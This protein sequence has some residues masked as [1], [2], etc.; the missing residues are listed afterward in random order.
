MR[1]PKFKYKF[2][3]AWVIILPLLMSTSCEFGDTNIDPVNPVPEEVP[4]NLI[5][6]S[7]EAQAA[8][9]IGALGGRMPGIVMQYYSGFDAQQVAYEN[10]NITEV[11]LNNLWNTGMY[12]GVMKDCTIMIE[13]AEAEGNP[14]YTGIAKILL[15]H[16]LGVTTSFFG[17]LPYSDAFQGIDN[18]LPIYDTQEQIYGTI[19]TLLDEAITALSEPSYALPVPP[20]NTDVVFRGDVSKWIAVARSLKARHYMHLT[21]KGTNNAQLALDQIQTGVIAEVANE[22]A[23]PFEAAQTGANPYF[24][25]GQQRPRTLIINQSFVDRLAANN[26]PRQPY[27]YNNPED[28]D[29]DPVFDFYQNDNDS[30]YWSQAT[31]PIPLISYAEVKLIE[32]EAIVRTG[33]SDA[34]AIAALQEAISTNM[35]KISGERIS[36]DQIEAYIASRG[37]FDGLTTMDEKI[38]RIIEEKYVAMYGQAAAEVWTDFRRTGF[39][40]ITPVADGEAGG[41]NPG[42]GIPQRFIYPIDERTTNGA[43]LQTAVDRQGGNLLNVV[44]WAFQP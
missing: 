8:Y 12:A 31:T 14:Y 20:G 40:A 33:G 36:S 38:Q 7:A 4:L 21:A 44:L 34:D 39:P 27:I 5:L 1:I 16:A 11:D 28:P 30:L 37:N 13:K 6:T 18:T 43:N 22:P 24:L 2:L 23:Y 32:A 17:D 9:N 25:F 19:Q 42:G 26:D 35:T 29:D 10:Y 41:L 15:A 3:Y